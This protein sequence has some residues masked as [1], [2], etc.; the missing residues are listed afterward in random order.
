MEKF[1]QKEQKMNFYFIFCF[2]SSYDYFSFMEIKKMCANEMKTESEKLTQIH[3]C[4]NASEAVM[5]LYGFTVN[6]WLIK[7]LASGVT[8][9]HSGEG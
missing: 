2:S 6:I 3:G 1:R 8:V 9:S 4:F 7:F 5:R